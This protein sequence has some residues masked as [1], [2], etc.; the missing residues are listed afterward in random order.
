MRDTAQRREIL[1]FLR[2]ERKHYT[3]SDV[4]E[5]VREKLP[6]ISLG[7]VYRNLGNLLEDGDIISVETSDK[8]VYYDGFTKDHA[9]FVCDGCKNIFDFPLNNDVASEITD[10]GFAV[11][12]K[13]V[14]YYGKCINCQ[15]Q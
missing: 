6:N 14:V 10:A 1:A 5:A 9:H 7:T 3:A 2:S 11:E 12:S 13:K 8:C 4:Y 15:E